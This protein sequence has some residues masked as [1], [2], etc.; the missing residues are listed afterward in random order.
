MAVAS[1]FLVVLVESSGL[2]NPSEAAFDHPPSGQEFEAFPLIGSEDELPSAA[3][4]FF[5][6]TE[7]VVPPVAPH[8][9]DLGAQPAQVP[10]AFDLA[11]AWPLSFRTHW[12]HT[13]R[14]NPDG[15]QQALRVGEDEPLWPL[16]QFAGVKAPGTAPA[17]GARPRRRSFSRSA[18][19]DKPRWARVSCPAFG[20]P[21]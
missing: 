5:D 19:P 17:C 18:N 7:Q 16:D 12:G 8:P 4:E 21:C 20:R 2:E 9:L 6:I 11:V 14:A 13:G 3:P 1:G 15:Q 10:V